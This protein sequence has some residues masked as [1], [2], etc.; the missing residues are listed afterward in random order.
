MADYPPLERGTGWRLYWYL[1]I[2]LLHTWQL[3]RNEHREVQ[4]IAGDYDFIFSDGKYGFHSRWTPSFILSHQIAFVPP[5]GCAR[6][7]G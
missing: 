3:I 5:K 6:P 2:D 4:A 7:H 1:F